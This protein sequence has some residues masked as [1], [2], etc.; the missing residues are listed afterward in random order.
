MKRTPFAVYRRVR[1]AIDWY[2]S[3]YK[4]KRDIKDNYGESINAYQDIQKITGI[5]HHSEKSFVEL[6]NVDGA[7]VKSKI[8]KGILCDGNSK[9]LIQQGDLVEIGGTLYS[10]TAAE[11]VLYGDKAIAWEISVEEQAKGVN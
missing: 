3:D 6:I 10:V 2:G 9:L 5:Y 7:S 11:P 1:L 8:N 4:F